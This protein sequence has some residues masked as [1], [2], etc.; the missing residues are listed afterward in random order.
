MLNQIIFDICCRIPERKIV[1]ASGEYFLK[2]YSESFK[3]SPEIMPEL[4]TNEFLKKNSYGGVVILAKAKEL[5]E[6]LVE[7]LRK[8]N[9]DHPGKM[10]DYCKVPEPF[11]GEIS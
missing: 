3:L 5:S 9:P 2:S 8:P 6:T 10:I 7:H 1:Y 4:F 11:S